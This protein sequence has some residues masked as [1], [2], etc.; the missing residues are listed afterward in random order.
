MFIIRAAMVTKYSHPKLWV[1]RMTLNLMF[2]QKQALK[3]M[4]LKKVRKHTL[5]QQ[6]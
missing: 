5:T 6:R 4:A 3:S 2:T 1:I